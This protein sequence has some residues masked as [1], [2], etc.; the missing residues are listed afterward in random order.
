[1]YSEG[2]AHIPQRKETIQPLKTKEISRTDIAIL[3]LRYLVLENSRTD[4]ETSLMDPFV[5]GASFT[6]CAWLFRQQQKYSKS[7]EN[8]R[9][10]DRCTELNLPTKCPQHGDTKLTRQCS[11]ITDSVRDINPLQFILCAFRDF[12]NTL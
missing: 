4:K 2:P 7:H 9:P 11:C 6:L 5:P 1:M 12:N 10:V 3:F 8:L